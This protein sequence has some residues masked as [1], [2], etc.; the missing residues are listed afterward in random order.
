MTRILILKISIFI[1]LININ[2]KS[3]AQWQTIYHPWDISST[4]PNLKSVYFF[5]Y[6]NGMAVGV[7]NS[8]SV[9]MIIRTT[10]S[11]ISWDTVFMNN[12][13]GIYSEIVFTNSN[14]AF[15]IGGGLIAKSTD[16]GNNWDTITVTT[17]TL[18]SIFFSNDSIGYT[19]GSNGTILKTS[20]AGTNWFVLN[21]T[22]TS[23]LTSVFFINDTIGFACANGFILKTTDGGLNWSLNNIGIGSLSFIFFSSDSIGYF[24]SGICFGNYELYKTANGGDNWTLH[25]TITP[26]FGCL[27]SMFFT[28]DTT[29]YITGQFQILKTIDGGLTWYFQNSSP[30]SGGNFLD[31]L[32]DVFFLNNDTGFAVGWEGQFYKTTNRGECVIPT[33][34][35]FT[36]SVSTVYF[37]DSMF[38]STSWLWGFGDGGS[39]TL[40]NPVHTY[41]SAGIYNVCLTAASICDT[42]MICDNINVIISDIPNNNLSRSIEAEIY[43]NPFSATSTIEYYLTKGTKSAEIIIFNLLGAAVKKYPLKMEH[44]TL[45]ISA[46]D[47]TAGIYFCTLI[48]D[49]QLVWKKKIVVVN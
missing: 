18:H 26:F 48:S 19:V 25:S 23:T 31:D 28:N 49:Y 30:P 10:D 44:N 13:F 46:G 37:Y 21:S 14:T 4:L 12:I 39:S 33:G 9:G 36:D 7:D 3:I 40:Q 1:L 8:L 11:G 34:F 24:L 35:S 45:T 2:T 5:D 42:V 15:A 16:F 41:S 47:L 29:G 32:M 6:N 17:S 20:D 22:V 38:N 27:T 43:P